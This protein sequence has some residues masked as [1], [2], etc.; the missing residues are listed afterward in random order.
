MVDDDSNLQLMLVKMLEGEGY[1]LL[2]ANDGVHAQEVINAAGDRISAVILDWSM[3]RMTGIEFLQWAKEQQRFEHIPMIMHTVLTGPEQMRA[4]IDAGAFYYLPKPATREVI[5]S[6]VRAAVADFR[7]HKQLLQK[8]QESEAPFRTLLE[9]HFRFRTLSEGEQL[10]VCIANCCPEPE[11]AAM[12]MEMITN[13]VEHGNLGIGYEDKSQF[14]AQG[15]WYTEIERRLSLP[16]HSSKFVDVHIERHADRLT[17]LIGD[18]GKGF[19]FKK[20]L[21]LD[22]KRL[23]DNHGRGIAMARMYLDLAYQGAGNQVLVTIPFA[24]Q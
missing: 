3:P 22:E 6:I 17:V 19:D 1:E 21:T 24:N 2:T 13:A 18:T 20:Y 16:E 10:A 12:I 7:E 8:L 23:L 11:R 9:G 15:T 5:H 4:G 14:M